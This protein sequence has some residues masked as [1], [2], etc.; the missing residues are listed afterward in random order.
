MLDQI[1]LENLLFLD[2]ET[3]TE[4]DELGDMSLAK[5]QLWKERTAHSSAAADAQEFFEQEASL[6]AEFAKVVCIS[7]GLLFRTTNKT[8]GLRIKSFCDRDEQKLLEQFSKLLNQHFN[9]PKKVTLC[10]HNIKEFD[11][12]FLCRRLVIHNMSVPQLLEAAFLKPWE[13]PFLDTIHLWRFGTGRHFVSLRLLREVLE[14][15]HN[16]ALPDGRAVSRLFWLQNDLQQIRSVCE[17]DVASV[18]QMVL[19]LKGLPYIQ[20]AD[21]ESAA[22]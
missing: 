18:A 4:T 16:A 5:Q 10:G 17:Q 11:V 7:V 6:H 14:I 12:P 21:I 8:L 19:R 15:P 1:N 2:I 13:L 9:N 3:V 22:G 20:A